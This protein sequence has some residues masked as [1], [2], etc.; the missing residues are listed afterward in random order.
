MDKDDEL[1]EIYALEVDEQSVPESQRKKVKIAEEQEM[2]D[3]RGVREQTEETAQ[4]R[5][6][7]YIK[8]KIKTL[9]I[10]NEELL[11]K[12]ID[13][14]FNITLDI[15]LPDIYQK[16]ITNQHLKLSNYDIVS[17]NEFVYNS[18]T[19][20]NFKIDEETFN[21]LA[22]SHLKVGIEGQDVSGSFMMN[23]LLLAKNFK[24]EFKI[25]LE[26]RYVV[27]GEPESKVPQKQTVN[28][29]TTTVSK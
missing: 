1:D 16:R 21:Q 5:D 8:L 25:P 15:P 22:T 29:A 4:I 9:R 14:T 12:L 20:Y 28:K 26:K 18:L 2:Q 3:E 6:M 17:F 23:K 24:M 19:L 11:H 27:G 7:K 13:H 10:E